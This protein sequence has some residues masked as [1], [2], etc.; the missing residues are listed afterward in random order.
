MVGAQEG[1]GGFVE[2]RGHTV[3]I[4]FHRHSSGS[5]PPRW[6]LFVFVGGTVDVLV[7]GNGGGEIVSHHMAVDQDYDI[8]GI[9]D[10]NGENWESKV[11]WGELES[12][13]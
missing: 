12:T 7:I 2:E 8:V 5:V 3:S 4:G 13:G 11:R 1:K 10:L 9:H 6:K